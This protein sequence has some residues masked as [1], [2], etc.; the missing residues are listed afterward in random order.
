MRKTQQ[1]VERDEREKQNRTEF[2][3]TENEI[4]GRKKIDQRHCND[5]DSEFK[6]KSF[7][8]EED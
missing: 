3:Q 8:N 2:D 1:Q 6:N 7:K 4:K 5:T